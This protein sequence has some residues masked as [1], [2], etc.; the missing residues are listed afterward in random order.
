MKQYW[1]K[2]RFRGFGIEYWQSE[3]I[4]NTNR[5]FYYF[6]IDLMDKEM[7]DAWREEKK[8][9]PNGAGVWGLHKFWYDCPHAQLNLYFI[10]IGWSSPW[11]TYKEPVQ[12]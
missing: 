4:L 2:F 5:Y 6:F 7:R 9:Y 3:K 11:T 10:C 12:Q 1:W 8:E